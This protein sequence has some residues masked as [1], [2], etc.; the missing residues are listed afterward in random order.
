MMIFISPYLHYL[1]MS[2]CRT[3]KSDRIYALY[4]K[5]NMFEL[6]ILF[7]VLKDIKNAFNTSNK[8]MMI[9]SY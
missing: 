8:E 6:L 1:I 4:V 3:P 9:I 2:M 7:Y 5:R